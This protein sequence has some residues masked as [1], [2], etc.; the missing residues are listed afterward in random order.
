MQC[1]WGLCAGCLDMGMLAWSRVQVDS[2]VY[3]AYSIAARSLPRHPLACNTV[4]P[5]CM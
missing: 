1:T 2:E 3:E 5:C 4:Q